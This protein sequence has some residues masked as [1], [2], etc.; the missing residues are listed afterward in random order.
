MST[1]SRESHGQPSADHVRLRPVRDG[2]RDALTVVLAYIPFALA[3]GATLASTGV[4]PVVAWSSSPLMFGGAAQLVAVQ[5][6]AGGSSVAVVVVTAL[7]VN[8]RHLLYSA[9][10]ALHTRPWSR[11]SRAFAAYFL[12]DPVYALA[13]ARFE[14]TPGQDATVRL[15]Y[16]L[17]MAVTLWVGWLG[18]TAGGGLLAGALPKA[19]P[20]ELAAPL[21]FLLLLI[22][23]LKDAAGYV[24]AAVAGFVAV[25]ASGLPLG[26]GLLSAAVA[27]MVAGAAT[28]RTRHV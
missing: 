28:E 5:L 6:L 1:M 15:R 21:T 3:L 17:A 23:T 10:L 12:A 25:A 20:L 13:T 9:S 8:S 16:Y 19:L 18:L 7:V 14:N 4:N 26:L 11:R 24:A 27:G 2:F 22:P